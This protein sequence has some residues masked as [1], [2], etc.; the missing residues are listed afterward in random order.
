[1]LFLDDAIALHAVDTCPKYPLLVPARNENPLEVRN[2]FRSLRIAIFRRPRCTRMDEGGGRRNEIRAGGCANRQIKLQYRG[3]GARQSPLGQRSG[4]VRGI[5]GRSVAGGRLWI[6]R[7]ST[8][9]RYWLNAPPSS[10][11]CPAHRLGFGPNPV[12]LFGRRD[13]DGGLIVAQKTSISGQ[14]AL[15][16]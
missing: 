5:Y 8:E 15:Q 1:M 14:F 6:R 9:L 16:W 13:G 12:D 7:I 2:A 11:G 10:S 4:L 3:A